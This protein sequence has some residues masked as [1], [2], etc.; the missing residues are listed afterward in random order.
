MLGKS[1]IERG[2]ALLE[3]LVALAILAIVLIG[4]AQLLPIA[5]TANASTGRRVFLTTIA[6]QKIE[7]LH[8]SSWESVDANLGAFVDHLDRTGVIVPDGSP[9][10]VFTRRWSVFPW[11]ADPANTRVFDVIVSSGH[12]QVRFGSVRTRLAP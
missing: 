4:L 2:F 10:V 3:V 9:L 5:I 7:D 8:A 11:D 6:A 1:P 12:E